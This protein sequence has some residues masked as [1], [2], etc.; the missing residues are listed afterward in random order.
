MKVKNIMFSGFMAAVLMSVAGNAS[1]AVS[2]ASQGYVDQEISKLNTSVSTTYLT[3]E[4]AA[5][6]YATTQYVTENVTNVLGNE[7]EGLVADVAA[8]A[9]AIENLETTKA[10]AADVYTKTEADNLLATK[11]D[12]DDV[13]KK[14]ETYT[15][16]EV[17]AKI[18]ET[19]AG[20]SGGTI[21]L[22]GYATEQYVK[23]AD[24]ANLTTAKTYTDE[25]IAKLS[26]EGGAIKANADAISALQTSVGE[27]SVADQIAAAVATQKTTDDAQNEKIT[28]LESAGYQTAGDVSTAI[29]TATSDMATKT[30]LADYAKQADLTAEVTARQTADQAVEAKLTEYTKTTDMSALATAEIPTECQSESSMC[31]LSFNGTSYAWTP[32]T[33][34]VE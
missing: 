26:A 5:D 2:V 27:T 10:N 14:T 15:Q 28:A 25:E 6:T 16:S 13:Y 21:T 11:A 29:A 3:Q 19:L 17:E 18:T 1:A 24:A 9:S 20:I 32:L 7:T 22:D 4:D 31:V 8:N 30:E 23:D 34:P 12:L 33:A